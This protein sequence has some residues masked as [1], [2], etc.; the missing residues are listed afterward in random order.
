MNSISLFVPQPN[1]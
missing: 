1:P